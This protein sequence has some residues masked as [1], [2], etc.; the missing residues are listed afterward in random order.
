VLV[1]FGTRDR[2]VI[3][4]RARDLVRLVPDG[5][6]ELVPGAGHMVQEECAAEVNA[7]LLRFL[8]TD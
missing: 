4:R 7:T 2:V 3:P 1:M 6:L 5:T 8:G